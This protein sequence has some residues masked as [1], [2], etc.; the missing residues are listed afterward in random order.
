MKANGYFLVGSGVGLL[1]GFGIGFIFCKKTVKSHKV[2]VEGFDEDREVEESKED[3]VKE[4]FKRVVD[5][6]KLTE[7]KEKLIRNW[8]KPPLKVSEKEMAENMHP[9]DS[10]EDEFEV[11]DTDILEN[12]NEDSE[13]EPSDS[14]FTG[15]M[16]PL[17]AHEK[18]EDKLKDIH[19]KHKKNRHMKPEMVSKEFVEDNEDTFDKEEWIFWAE[20][21]VVSDSDENIIDDYRR[22]I[23]D[24]IDETGFRYNEEDELIIFSHEYATIYEITKYFKKYSD[25]HMLTKDGINE[26]WVRREMEYEGDKA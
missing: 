6:N 5:S 15:S 16:R 10:D 12:G 14:P 18:N 24:F 25:T 3:D 13:E 4:E 23:G 19:H 17:E 1:I 7:I 20:D 9:L 26:N 2:F 8:D 21:G 11:D 22:F